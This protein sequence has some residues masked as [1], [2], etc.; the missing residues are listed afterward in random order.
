MFSSYISLLLTLFTA[1]EL[2][3][4]YDPIITNGMSQAFGS[5][6]TPTGGSGK[7]GPGSASKSNRT[8][9]PETSGDRARE[10][11]A[12]KEAVLDLVYITENVVCILFCDSHKQ[13]YTRGSHSFG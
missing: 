13:L 1:D 7:N 12:R 8:R 5:A 3:K 6:S 10:V 2:R 4:V 9:T 11:V